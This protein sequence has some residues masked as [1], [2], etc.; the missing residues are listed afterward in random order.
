MSWT[1]ALKVVEEVAKLAPIATAVIALRAAQIAVYSIKTQKSL[2]QNRAS[3]DFFLK[4]EM[5]SAMLAAYDAYE[6]ALALYRGLSNKQDFE[7]HHKAAYKAMRGYLNV[8][9]LLATGVNSGIFDEKTC[10]AF[11]HAE[12]VEAALDCGTFIEDITSHPGEEDT[13]CELRRLAARWDR[14]YTATQ[15]ATA[16]TSVPA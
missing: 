15:T 7:K 16:P 14:R 12:L 11:W 8:H 2:V 4:T 1:V 6:E 9:E 13:Y 3:I 5:D 10:H